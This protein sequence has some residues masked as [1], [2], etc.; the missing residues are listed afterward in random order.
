VD[1]TE[2]GGVLKRADTTKAKSKSKNC[3]ALG[4]FGGGGGGAGSDS[5]DLI[6]AAV[7]AAVSANSGKGTDPDK[8]VTMSELFNAIDGLGA[9]TGRLLFMTTNQYVRIHRC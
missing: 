4:E 6:A 7:A 3:S 9:Q 8:K 5:G 1:V 2:S